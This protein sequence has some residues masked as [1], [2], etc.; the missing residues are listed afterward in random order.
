MMIKRITSTIVLIIF[1]IISI[2][3]V[4]LAVSPVDKPTRWD[5]VNMTLT[6]LLNS[7]WQVSAHGTS[8]AATSSSPGVNGYDE[9]QFTFLLIKSGKYIIC[10]INDPRPSAAISS[11]RRLN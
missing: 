2:E 3:N 8:R 10:F 11:C 4:A 9:T 5:P 1:S 7:G 6:E